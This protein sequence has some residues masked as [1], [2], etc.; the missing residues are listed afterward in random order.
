MTKGTTSPNEKAWYENRFKA[1]KEQKKSFQSISFREQPALVTPESVGDFEYHRSLG[2][3]GEYPFTRG[4]QPTMYR[5]RWWTMRQ[6]AGFGSP[7][8][9][10]QRF[11]Y[12]LEAGQTGLSTA[13]DI[14]A[15]K[16]F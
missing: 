6:F 7:E 4:V 15:A 1:Q 12:L 16:S 2:Y 11:K 5:G 14:I 10:N 3:P 8:D 9:T 13:F